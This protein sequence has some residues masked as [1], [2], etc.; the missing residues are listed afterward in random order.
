LQSFL[1]AIIVPDFGG[2]KKWA[3]ANGKDFEAIKADANGNADLKKAIL[4]ELNALATGNKFNGLERVKKMYLR[5]TE[6]TIEEDLLTPSMK[7]KRPV[8]A[9]FFKSEIDALYGQ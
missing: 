9:K 1:I 8:A 6:F 5:Q 4:D 7:L 3:A 2:V